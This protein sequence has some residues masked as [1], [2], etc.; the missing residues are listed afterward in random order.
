MQGFSKRNPCPRL[1]GVVVGRESRRALRTGADMLPVPET[2]IH[3]T[4][5]LFNTI[6]ILALMH[7]KCIQQAAL[8][9]MNF[10]AD[11]KRAALPLTDATGLIS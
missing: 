10:Q 2:L 7:A 4:G 5:P 11:R 8:T 6:G 1:R 9:C 3:C